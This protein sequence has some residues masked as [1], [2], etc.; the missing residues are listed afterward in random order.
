MGLWRG[1]D[2]DVCG[3]DMLESGFGM[4]RENGL[5]LAMSWGCGLWVVPF[6]SGLNVGFLLQHFGFFFGFIRVPVDGKLLLAI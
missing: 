5:G 4:R 6:P 3:V 2:S 1:Q